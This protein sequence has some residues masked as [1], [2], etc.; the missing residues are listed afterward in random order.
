MKLIRR[1]LVVVRILAACIFLELGA[2]L[3]IEK[4]DLLLN[5]PASKRYGPV[6]IRIDLLR[7]EECRVA[8]KEQLEI[9]IVGTGDRLSA[10]DFGQI[11]T[12]TVAL[13]EDIRKQTK[14]GKAQN[15]EVK[16]LSMNS[17]SK[18]VLERILTIP[19]KPCAK[20]TSPVF[21]TSMTELNARAMLPLALDR[22]LEKAHDLALHFLNGVDSVLYRVKPFPPVII[23]GTFADHVM[24]LVKERDAEKIT[25]EYTTIEGRIDG[26]I[27]AA[28][29]A[30]QFHLIHPLTGD[31]IQCLFEKSQWEE[32]AGLLKKKSRLSVTG[33]ASVSSTGDILSI[34]V[35]EYEELPIPADQPSLRKLKPI[36][37]T[38]GRGSLEHIRLVRN[39]D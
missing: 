37:I 21:L 34:K 25:H 15:W 27:G 4:A 38:R 3:P 39:G 9:E 33:K 23:S 28:G 20:P 6:C 8:N 1:L 24:Q 14:S 16:G 30:Q 11:V 13:L 31:K 12:Q 32:L 5:N 10:K 26:M 19:K 29:E 7:K 22:S 2:S 17:P 18:V 35:D 36:D